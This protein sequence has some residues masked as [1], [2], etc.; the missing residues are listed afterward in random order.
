LYFG[1]ISAPPDSAASFR[2]ILTANDVRVVEAL[3]DFPDMQVRLQRLSPREY[4]VEARLAYL[5]PPGDFAGTIRVVTDHPEEKDI[6]VPF[7]GVV[8]SPAAAA[9]QATANR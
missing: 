3:S 8:E 9:P 6:A 2:C 7:S 5:P 1:H 4:M